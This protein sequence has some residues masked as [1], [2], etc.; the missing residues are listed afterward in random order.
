[1]LLISQ[2]N[3]LDVNLLHVKIIQ[4]NLTQFYLAFVRHGLA[5]K[6]FNGFTRKFRGVISYM[7]TI[8]HEEYF[9]Y[10]PPLVKAQPPS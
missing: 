10:Q 8:N 5:R 2:D 4:L 9:K 1:M 3:E 7:F 6:F